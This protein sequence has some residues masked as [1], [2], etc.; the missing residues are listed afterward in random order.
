MGY[1]FDVSWIAVFVA[2]IA[3]MVIGMTWYNP[4]IFGEMRMKALNETCNMPNASAAC[5]GPGAKEL[6]S[7]FLVA[8]LTAFVLALFIGWTASETSWEGAVIGFFAA[9]GF[10]VT[11]HYSGVIWS[12]KP[13][14]A[15][16][17]DA[18]YSLIALTIMGGLI[19]LIS[20]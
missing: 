9:L 7:G 10:I 18:A 14:T 2:A 19:G 12:K 11:T 1:D 16:Y 8:L 20:Y 13:L 6:I 3:D 5:P 4:K 17:I 15:F